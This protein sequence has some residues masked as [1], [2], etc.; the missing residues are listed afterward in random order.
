MLHMCMN[1]SFQSL[2]ALANNCANNDLM[3]SAPDFNQLLFK[4]VHVID[5]RHMTLR[6]LYS[7][8]FK[9]SKVGAA[10]VAA[11]EWSHGCSWL[12]AIQLEHE[13]VR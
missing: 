11:A 2:S 7:T 9:S 3:Q 1:T 5:T 6:I 10:H 12:C 4:F 8:G 13:R